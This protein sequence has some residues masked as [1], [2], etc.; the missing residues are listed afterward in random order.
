MVCLPPLILSTNL[1]VSWGICNNTL[2]NVVPHDSEQYQSDLDSLLIQVRQSLWTTMHLEPY[3]SSS[4]DP[5]P[6]KTLMSWFWTTPIVSW[7]WP[8]RLFQVTL[9]KPL[10]W[11]ASSILSEDSC[12]QLLSQLQSLRVQVNE[13]RA[14]TKIPHWASWT[15]MIAKRLDCFQPRRRLRWDET[16]STC[17][18]FCRIYSTL[19]VGNRLDLLPYPVLNKSPRNERPSELGVAFIKAM[20]R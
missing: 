8:L 3:E 7:W 1:A 10:E 9:D 15:L 5:T 11:I 2:S 6:P 18:K 17:W 4:L 19:Q 12:E 14:Q 20:L 13:Q 16:T